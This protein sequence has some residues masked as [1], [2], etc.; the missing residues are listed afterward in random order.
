M[1]M[2]RVE[3]RVFLSYSHRDQPIARELGRELAERGATVWIDQEMLALGDRLP[4]RITEAIRNS[5]LF[6]LLVSPASAQSDWLR[7][8]L[9]IALAGVNRTRVIPVRLAGAEIPADL[10]DI[11]YLDA[12]SD[13]LGSA[14]DRV[15]GSSAPHGS[16]PSEASSAKKIEQI[17]SKLGLAWQR[18]PAIAGVRPDFLVET[19]DGKRLIIEAKSRSNPSLLEAVDARSQ[20]AHL[21]ELTGADDAVVVVPQLEKALPIAGLLGLAD[22]TSYL[23][24]FTLA[25]RDPA[26]A[27]GTRPEPQPT[28]EK[29]IVFASMPFAPQYQDVYW[30]AMTFAAEAVG[31]T[32]VRVDREDFDDDI[33]HKIK[34][35]IESSIAVIADLSDSNS[36]VLYELGYARRHGCPCVHI[37]STALDELPF[38]VRNVNT[39]QYKQGQTHE[40]REPLTKRLQAVIA[41][42]A[43]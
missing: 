37:C 4:E 43:D 7:Q 6:L 22:L 26:Q 9:E 8:E 29:R 16:W 34:R 32:C 38:N 41:G 35:Y 19:P 24:K 18:E 33:P 39:L 23:R 11:V 25:S 10:A 42:R 1:Q 20:A 3:P 28:A 15:L 36:D 13:D 2:S 27:T 17:L 12:D 31:A 21:R 5:D 40:L 14:A 30:V